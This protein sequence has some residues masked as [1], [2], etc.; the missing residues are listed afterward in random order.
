MLIA[1]RPPV[2][3]AVIPGRFMPGHS[4]PPPLS[5]YMSA[6]GKTAHE[7]STGVILSRADVNA[8]WRALENLAPT[9]KSEPRMPNPVDVQLPNNAPPGWAFRATGADKRTGAA[10]GTWFAPDGRT[11][12]NVHATDTPWESDTPTQPFRRMTPRVAPPVG[13]NVDH[14]TTIRER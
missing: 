5:Y 13:L 7:L 1:P 9:W 10:V 6:D 4:Y 14:S 3:V 2:A 8:R 12:P 11:F